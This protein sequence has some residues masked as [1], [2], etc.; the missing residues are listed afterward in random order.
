MILPFIHLYTTI[1]YPFFFF[2]L[3]TI[4]YPIYGVWEKREG[5]SHY[6]QSFSA[7]KRSLIFSGPDDCEFETFCHWTQD[8]SDTSPHPWMINSGATA[9]SG[10]GPKGDHT[11]GT[12]NKIAA[13]SQAQGLRKD[14]N[15][16]GTN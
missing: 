5:G 8:T 9:S 15:S 2:F 4:L 1:L 6:P 11:S 10:T 16:L 3:F 14:E 12:G 13:G 7:H